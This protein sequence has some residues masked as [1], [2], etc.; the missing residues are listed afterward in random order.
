MVLP[1][2]L[3]FL[4]TYAFRGTAIS[5]V[6]FPGTLKNIGNYAFYNCPNLSGTLII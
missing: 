2:A 4:G 6:T 5:S 1:N 3:T